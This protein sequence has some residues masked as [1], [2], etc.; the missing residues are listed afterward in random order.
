A[1]MASLNRVFSMD[2]HGGHFFTIWYGV[3]T[4]QTRKLSFGGGGH[5]PALLFSGKDA[6]TATKSSLE[7]E[8]PPI[9]MD[10]L[11]PVDNLSVELPQFARLLLYSD[12]AVEVG[13]PNLKI[14]GQDDFNTFVAEIRS[15]DTIIDRV[16]SRARDLRGGDVLNDDCSVMRIDF[17]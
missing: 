7:P 4:P 10:P 2:R 3:Y 5:P 17:P 14:Y 13:D 1:V 9:G 16:V 11:L 8:G 12:G 6:S 15:D